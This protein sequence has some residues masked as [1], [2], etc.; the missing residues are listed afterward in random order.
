MQLGVGPASVVVPLG[1]RNKHVVRFQEVVE[2]G[3]CLSQCEC[4]SIHYKRS[5]A[6]RGLELCNNA[7][8]EV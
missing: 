8:V 7:L 3:A 6:A 2:V 5:G 4:S 1:I